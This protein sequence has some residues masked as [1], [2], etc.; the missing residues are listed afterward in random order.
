MNETQSTKKEQAEGPKADVAT[1]AKPKTKVVVRLLPPSVTEEELLGLVPEELKKQITWRKF[2]PGSHFTQA[3]GDGGCMSKTSVWFLNCTSPA[4]AEILIRTFHNKC[5]VDERHTTFKAIA[6]LAPYQKT[7]RKKATEK[8][9]EGQIEEEPLYA[10]FLESLKD[11]GS[12]DA[13]STARGE[14]EQLEIL[15]DD[16]GTP[17]TAMLLEMREKYNVKTTVNGRLY[18]LAMLRDNV[19]F[20]QVES[21]HG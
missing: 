21:T 17:I 10:S 16:E 12:G 5:F 1:K 18:T 2:Y 9:L 4:A 7:P 15:R 13:N 3:T 11:G 20:S 6:G 14:M 8:R 19:S